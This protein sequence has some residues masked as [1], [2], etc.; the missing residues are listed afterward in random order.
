MGRVCLEPT[1]LWA[2]MSR[3]HTRQLVPIIYGVPIRSKVYFLSVTLELFY[4]RR[5]LFYVERKLFYVER[6]IINV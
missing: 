1:L 6:K 3:N 2:E 5:K 4:V